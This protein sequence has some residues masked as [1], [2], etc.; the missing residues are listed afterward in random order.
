M[1]TPVKKNRG[2][3]PK[4]NIDIEMLQKLAMHPLTLEVCCEILEVSVDTIHKRKDA[5]AAW[6]KG[7]AQCKQLIAQNL[8]KLSQS[9]APVAIFLAKALLGLRDDGILDDDS[10]EAR[11]VIDETEPLE[12]GV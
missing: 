11:L 9:S 7:R 6:R 12:G 1:N 4:K 10:P 2:G 8:I 3:R 5:M